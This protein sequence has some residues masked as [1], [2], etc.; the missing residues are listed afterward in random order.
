MGSEARIRSG[1]GG[2]VPGKSFPGIPPS[3]SGLRPTGNKVATGVLEEGFWTVHWQFGSTGRHPA[4]DVRKCEAEEYPAAAQ[5]QD[6]EERPDQCGARQGRRDAEESRARGVEDGGH[7]V[8]QEKQAFR[9]A[10]HRIKNGRQEEPELEDQRQPFLDVLIEGGE[11]NEENP[12]SD[13]QS[14]QRNES[15]DKHPSER[16]RIETEE[17]RGGN[18]EKKTQAGVEQGFVESGDNQRFAR[19]VNLRQHGLRLH[20]LLDRR[21]HGLV[22]RLPEDHPGEDVNR[23][24]YGQFFKRQDLPPLKKN[25]GGRHYD[26]RRECPEPAQDGLAVERGDVSHKQTLGEFATGKQVGDYPAEKSSRPA[27]FRRRVENGVPVVGGQRGQIRARGFR[28][29]FTFLLRV[30]W[31]LATHSPEVIGKSFPEIIVMLSAKWR[32]A[33]NHTLFDAH[34]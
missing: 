23:V 10:P 4:D 29:A 27:Q 1:A 25:E 21:K 5:A 8:E 33:V 9:I 3:P 26:D 34:S 18:P 32:N 20:H 16:E 22:K 30:C 6:D 31:Y 17:K 15:R 7:G 28:L 24:R 12:D 2:R 11:R 13:P 14:D 19:E